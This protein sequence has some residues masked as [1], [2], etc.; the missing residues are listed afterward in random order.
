MRAA[1]GR[2]VFLRTY[3][4]VLYVHPAAL[5]VARGFLLFLEVLCFRT[6]VLVAREK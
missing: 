5:C 3:G 1:R 2:Y 4:I 6:V